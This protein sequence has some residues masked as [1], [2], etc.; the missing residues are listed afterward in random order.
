M[1]ILPL[2][3]FCTAEEGGEREEEKEEIIVNNTRLS[4]STVSWA[5]EMLLLVILS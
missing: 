2:L 3:S 5:V 1:L 4:L